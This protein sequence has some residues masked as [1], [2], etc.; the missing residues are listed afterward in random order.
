MGAKRPKI[1]VFLKFILF[2]NPIIY[3]YRCF[4][5]TY[6][7]LRIWYRGIAPVLILNP[8]FFHSLILSNILFGVCR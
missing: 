3:L 8:T 7:T 5:N 2:T 6:I 1:P 4:L